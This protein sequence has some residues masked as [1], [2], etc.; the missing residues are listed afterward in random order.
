MSIGHVLDAFVTDNAKEEK[1]CISHYDVC[2]LMKF[3]FIQYR[4]T[5]P[6]EDCHLN[7]NKSRQ[8]KKTDSQVGKRSNSETQGTTA[9]VVIATTHCGHSQKITRSI[10]ITIITY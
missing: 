7:F 8:A 10:T 6:P 5:Q 2:F 3:K 1:G 4:G 9:A